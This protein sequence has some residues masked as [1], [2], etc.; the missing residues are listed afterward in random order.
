MH[1]SC[2]QAKFYMQSYYLIIEDV[3]KHTV[4]TL[5]K[6]IKA[7]SLHFLQQM[8]NCMLRLFRYRTTSVATTQ[9]FSYHTFL[10]N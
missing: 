5:K 8:I 7:T 9:C 6:K 2:C 3:C 1:E 10:Y 4:L